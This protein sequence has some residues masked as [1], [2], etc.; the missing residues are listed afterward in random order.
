MSTTNNEDNKFNETD[1]TQSS[2]NTED[3]NKTE[4]ASYNPTLVENDCED[5][6]LERLKG[7]AI[8]DTLYSE[9]F[10]LNT[11]LKL[12]QLEKDLQEEDEIERDLCSLWDMTLEE[13]VVKYLLKHDVLELFAN[14]I[15]STDDKR[16]TEILVGILGNMCNVQQTRNL[17]TEKKEVIETLLELSNCM[18]S[19]TLEQLMRLLAVVFV[20]MSEEQIEK[21]YNLILKS[22]K[23][24]ENLCFILNNAANNSLI[25]QTMETLNA[26]LAKF[27]VL[28]LSL[29][30]ENGKSLD[31]ISKTSFEELFVQSEMI[32]CSIEAFKTL[33]KESANK[34]DSYE[35][36]EI[37]E[38]IHKAKQTF[39]NIHSILTQYQQ[40]SRDAYET[41]NDEIIKCFKDIL[42]PM[43]EDDSITSWQ[44]YEQDVLE[45]LND[46]LRVLPQ[47]LDLDIF[48]YLLKLFYHVDKEQEKQLQ[49]TAAA[50][51]EFESDND[52]DDDNEIDHQISY[53]II[54]NT[55]YYLLL[56][57]DK[58]LL[59]QYVAACPRIY[60][61]KLLESFEQPLETDYMKNCYGK[62]KEALD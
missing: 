56:K 31:E 12:G 37:P 47:P 17:L 22:D 13:D 3:A 33:V 28:K 48:S 46:V 61:V 60:S 41:S 40:L 44:Q 27:F 14:I 9:R 35:A 58:D 1:K 34:Q 51:N 54:L 25:L 5:N 29:A 21:W 62:L 20:K 59:K 50:S 6:D 26:I 24:V 36:A 23:F 10:V 11:L 4:P 57:A 45:T 2:N 8:G 16:L 53:T 55:L 52:D 43:V 15:K 38:S 18:D 30:T 19:L 49:K 42:R 7:D 39:C 32:E